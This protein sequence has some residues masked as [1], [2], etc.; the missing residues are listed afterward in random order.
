MVSVIPV[1][2]A[3]GA[4]PTKVMGYVM[5][6]SQNPPV[7]PAGAY[8]VVDTDSN[9][10]YTYAD[11]SFVFADITIGVSNCAFTVTKTGYAWYN[12]YQSD[13]IQAETTI[14]NVSLYNGTLIYG[15]I[16]GHGPPM[17]EV[18]GAMI[19]ADT[20]GYNHT[21][22]LRIWSNV[23]GT[24]ALRLP[25]GDGYVCVAHP[26][27]AGPIIKSKEN[28]QDGAT[29]NLNFELYTGA[30]ISGHVFYRDTTV[31]VANAMV[32]TT[33]S[34]FDSYGSPTSTT[35]TAADGS[36]TLYQV[37]P[38]APGRYYSHTGIRICQRISLFYSGAGSATYLRY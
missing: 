18:S 2:P 12:E 24:Y 8:V 30:M 10:M 9:S 32:V 29:Y 13:I 20:Q 25:P 26:D 5:D 1:I 28:I 11:G 35:Y 22:W 14:K 33:C 16:T 23:D 27:Y 19:Q 7:P 17:V 36:Y 37:Y 34:D 15:T 4:T 38:L 21:P 31:T 3:Q 6:A